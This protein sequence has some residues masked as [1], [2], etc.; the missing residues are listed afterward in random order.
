VEKHRQ[1]QLHR[2][3]Q[4]R[5]QHLFLLRPRGEVTVEIQTAFAH[6]TDPRF[7]QQGAQLFFRVQGPV[8]GRMRVNAGGAEQPRAAVIEVVAQLQGL[9]T[10]VDAGAGE[11]QLANTRGVRAVQHI[12]LFG[13]EAGVGQV[14]ADVD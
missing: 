11:H 5:F 10:G 9:F 8:A 4:V 12:T 13:G 6:R 2:Q 1:L 7:H 14:D 3:R